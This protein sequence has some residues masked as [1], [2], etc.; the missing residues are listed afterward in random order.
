MGNF[1]LKILFF[2]GYRCYNMAVFTRK[3]KNG[4]HLK[5][6]GYEEDFISVIACLFSR[7]CWMLQ[8]QDMAEAAWQKAGRPVSKIYVAKRLPA[9]SDAVACTV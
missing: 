3:R 8:L 2:S 9:G 6:D 1:F 5:E 7:D 4:N